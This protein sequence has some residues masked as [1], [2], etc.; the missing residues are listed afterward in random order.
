MQRLYSGR[1]LLF[2]FDVL[3]LKRN[4]HSSQRFIYH[5]SGAESVCELNELT[6][7]EGTS[8][9]TPL[10]DDGGRSHQNDAIAVCVGA[11]TVWTRQNRELQAEPALR[12]E[13]RAPRGS[14]TTGVGVDTRLLRR[15]C[16]FSGA[17]G[18]W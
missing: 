17:Q 14:Q 7:L 13:V 1:D 11:G 5:G 9:P 16:D 2:D 15:P 12:K 8:F 4:S 18:A 3:H 6:R 10:D